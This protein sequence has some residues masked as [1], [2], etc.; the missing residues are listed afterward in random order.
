MQGYYFD[1][2]ADSFYLYAKK[3]WYIRFKTLDKKRE[4]C[5]RPFRDPDAG[6]KIQDWIESFEDGVYV[7]GHNSSGFDV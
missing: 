3:V 2:E 1:I 7:V 5:V 4:T 6:Q